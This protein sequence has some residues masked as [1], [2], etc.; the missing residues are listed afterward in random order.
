MRRVAD[1]SQDDK[2]DRSLRSLCTPYD[3]WAAFCPF[4]EHF[5]TRPPRTE[6]TA[7]MGLAG[8]YSGYQSRIRTIPDER[9]FCNSSVASNW[10]H[11]R[12][13]RVRI[14]PLRVTLKGT[15]WAGELT[16]PV[17]DIVTR[18]MAVYAPGITIQTDDEF[19]LKAPGRC[20]LDKH[21]NVGQ[22]NADRF[23]TRMESFAAPDEGV[24]FVASC[25]IYMPD[26]DY[27]TSAMNGAV[28]LFST[29]MYTIHRP[30]ICMI[31]GLLHEVMQ[32]A[33]G[34]SSCEN[35]GCLMNNH[36][37][38]DEATD[39][40]LLCPWCMRKL[41][42]NG[43]LPS[44]RT[45]VADLRHI[46]EDMAPDHDVRAN[47]ATVNGWAA[48]D[49]SVADVARELAA[50]MAVTSRLQAELV[51]RSE[52]AARSGHAGRALKRIKREPVNYDG[53]N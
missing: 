15:T 13:T 16:P 30:V 42:V 24:V 12:L 43:V 20:R 8:D 25:H 5:Y 4:D 6:S 37:G 38:I 28:V 44:V 23:V 46:L 26:L 39:S 9:V 41:Q 27:V 52:R 53:P 14:V 50:S 51:E 17:V 32:A 19:V 40:L 18:I 31:S 21:D 3:A 45:V 34:I 49:R 11:P 36:D 48:L 10:L 33:V 22:L 47:L 7:L 29:Y 2:I 35:M 1:R